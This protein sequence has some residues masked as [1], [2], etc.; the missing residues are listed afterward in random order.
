MSIAALTGFLLLAGV[1]AYAQ[2]LTGFAFGLITMGGVGLT[3]LLSLPDAAALVSV[4]T[5]VNASQ[6]LTKGWRDVA[7]RQFGLVMLTSL[8]FLLVGF[9]LLGWL[10]GSRADLL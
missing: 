2:T 8:P 9:A 6:M 4:L 5:L 3:G 7:W 1:A 10:A